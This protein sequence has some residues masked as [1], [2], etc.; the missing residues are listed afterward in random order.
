LY[1]VAP[2]PQSSPSLRERR[3]GLKIFGDAGK[4]LFLELV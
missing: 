3:K 1:I 2:S 4:E